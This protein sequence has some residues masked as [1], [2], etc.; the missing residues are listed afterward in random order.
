[1]LLTSHNKL[2]VYLDEEVANT[3]QTIGQTRFVLSQP[4]IV[5]DAAVVDLLHE[6]G[7]LP[8]HQHLVQTLA[9]ALL[10]PFE[11]KLEVDGQLQSTFLVTLESMNPAK[12][13]SLQT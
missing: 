9:P 12:N 1:M 4:V 5:R 13:R 10:H 6:L 2:Q 7:V 11:A 3:S 8:G